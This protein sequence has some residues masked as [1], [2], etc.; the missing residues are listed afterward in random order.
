MCVLDIKENHKLDETIGTERILSCGKN[1]SHL[2]CNRKLMV[3]K[4]IHFKTLRI[5]TF[6]NEITFIIGL[7]KMKKL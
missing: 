2:H 7:R 6:T 1:M 5:D 3:E 4:D